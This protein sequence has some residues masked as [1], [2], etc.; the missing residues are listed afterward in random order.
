MLS[1][2]NEESLPRVLP[3]VVA[4]N[5]TTYRV[6]LAEFLENRLGLDQGSAE[7]LLN[8]Y[9]QGWVSKS[10]GQE[11]LPSNAGDEGV[12]TRHPS[13]DTGS[14]SVE[15]SEKSYNT[16]RSGQGPDALRENPGLH[17]FYPNLDQ[18][19]ASNDHVPDFEPILGSLGACGDFSGELEVLSYD[20]FDSLPD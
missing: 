4:S 16:P 3:P 6:G 8:E 13:S 20:F 18:C 2:G 19:Q 12:D 7:N 5:E 15:Q 1:I 11:L 9:D 10:C 14:L 17:A